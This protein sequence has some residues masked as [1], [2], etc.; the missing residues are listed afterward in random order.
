MILCIY[1]SSI[2][3]LLNSTCCI[4]L[5][6]ATDTRSGHRGPVTKGQHKP[7]FTGAVWCMFY[8]QYLFLSQ[9]CWLDD[10]Q[11]RFRLHSGG[12]QV[13]VK[14]GKIPKFIILHKKEGI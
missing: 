9:W 1:V 13:K 10:H 3:R 7:N 4:M 8:G 14:K 12:G 2:K 11:G 6:E 5:L